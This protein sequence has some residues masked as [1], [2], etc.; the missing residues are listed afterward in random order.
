[1]AFKCEYCGQEVDTED[2]LEIEHRACRLKAAFP[3]AYTEQGDGLVT[4]DM[5]KVSES[6]GLFN[7]I[8]I[9]RDG[10]P[11]HPLEGDMHFRI[12][13]GWANPEVWIELP[14]RVGNCLSSWAFRVTE[15]DWLRLVKTVSEGL[16]AAR[17]HLEQKDSV[18]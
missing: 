1:M 8:V 17:K 2:E 5:R 3:G 10:Q 18:K 12:S 6:L 14:I 9:G 11:L 15:Q 16:D 13:A 7:D 4:F